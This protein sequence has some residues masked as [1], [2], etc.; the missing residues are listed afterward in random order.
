[1]KLLEAF[2]KM[3]RINDN[4]PNK[5]LLEYQS[6]ETERD[7]QIIRD[8]YRKIDGKKVNDKIFTDEEREVIDKLGGCIKIK[9]NTI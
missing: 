3:F 2:D 6:P 7:S 4:K 5:S 8:I 9:I 1:M